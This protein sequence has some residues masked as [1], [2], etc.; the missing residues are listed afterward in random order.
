MQSKRHREYNLQY[1]RAKMKTI[2][3]RLH[4][5]R[6]AELIRI[7]EAIPDKMAWFREK[8]EETKRK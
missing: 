7:Y 6:D 2:C 1:R 4:R 5:G 3:F 8:L